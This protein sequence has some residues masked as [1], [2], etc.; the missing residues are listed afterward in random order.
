M[1]RK[2]TG[3]EA[4]TWMTLYLKF[5]SGLG[6]KET[7]LGDESGVGRQPWGRSDRRKDNAA[8]DWASAFGPAGS[9]ENPPSIDVYYSKLN[10]SFPKHSSLTQI[11]GP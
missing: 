3:D 4:E 2:S 5:T 10:S 7:V 1:N 6:P 11:P 8:Q 9:L